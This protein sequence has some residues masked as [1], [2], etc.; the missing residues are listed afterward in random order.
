MLAEVAHEAEERVRIRQPKRVARGGYH[1]SVHDEAGGKQQRQRDKDPDGGPYDADLYRRPDDKCDADG[2]R[3]KR[4]DISVL[5]HE[6]EQHIN[7]AEI[8]PDE[9]S[10]LNLKGE[11][12]HVAEEHPIRRHRE[13]IEPVYENEFFEGPAC[14]ARDVFEDNDDTK[15]A[16][17]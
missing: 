9:T 5:G 2:N 11:V 8:V 14:E 1:E 12:P 7:G 16:R 17:D 13:Q 10:V 6:V 4:A 15:E 3:P